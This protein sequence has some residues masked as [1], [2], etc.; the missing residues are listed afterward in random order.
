MVIGAIDPPRHREFSSHHP[1]I[2]V[3]SPALAARSVAPSRRRVTIF[4]RRPNASWASVRTLFA[5]A[6]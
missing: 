6:Q 1:V 4:S 2:A 5:A 3:V